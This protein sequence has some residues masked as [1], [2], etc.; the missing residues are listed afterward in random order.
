[1]ASELHSYINVSYFTDLTCAVPGKPILKDMALPKQPD[2]SIETNT[3]YHPN[4]MPDSV[5]TVFP[6]IQ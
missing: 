4:V 2:V 1:M 5:V 6:E 3:I